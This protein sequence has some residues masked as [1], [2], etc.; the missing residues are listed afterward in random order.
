MWRNLCL[1][2]ML[3][4]H[5][6]VLDGYGSLEKKRNFYIIM[7]LVLYVYHRKTFWVWFCDQDTEAFQTPTRCEQK[8]DP[9]D[10]FTPFLTAFASSFWNFDRAS[11]KWV[12]LCQVG[13]QSDWP[14]A[15]KM[16]KNGI[17][18]VNLWT[19][20]GGSNFLFKPC[21]FHK[22]KFFRRK[23]SDNR[24]YFNN[25]RDSK[26]K[27]NSILYAIFFYEQLGIWIWAK[28]LWEMSSVKL[29]HN[30]WSFLFEFH[31]RF[32]FI[33]D[34]YNCLQCIVPSVKI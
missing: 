7:D 33:L 29:S 2:S 28:T 34:L 9:H 32:S 26:C 6:P 4:N 27:E 25:Q 21:S 14:N 24:K 16:G 17:Q 11:Q 5:P 18:R 12:V 8:M 31:I 13:V 15:V 20:G 19:R 1:N 23:T 10:K 30:K 3:F 22:I